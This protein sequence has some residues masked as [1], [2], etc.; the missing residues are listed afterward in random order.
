MCLIQILSGLL[1][2]IIAI[3]VAYI[4]YRQYKNDKDKLRFDLFEKRMDIYKSLNECLI[5]IFIKGFLESKYTYTLYHISDQSYFLFDK[6]I[7]KYLKEFRNNIDELNDI[8][9]MEIDRDYKD[10]FTKS[11]IESVPH[12]RREITE[13]FH[14]QPKVIKELFSQY[15]RFKIK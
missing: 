10:L 6:D 11:Q 7:D 2:P 9:K 12:R 5:N 14:K 1:T 3:V 8:H 4:A 13:W 15:L